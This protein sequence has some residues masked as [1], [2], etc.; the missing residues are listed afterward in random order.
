MC[1]RRRRE[2]R[3][4][5][6]GLAECRHGSRDITFGVR[7]RAPSKRDECRELCRLTPFHGD[8]LRRR[9]RHSQPLIKQERQRFLG[10][11]DLCKGRLRRH[12]VLDGS[13]DHI[14]ESRLESNR[15]AW[16]GGIVG[17][18]RSTDEAESVTVSSLVICGAKD[19]NNGVGRI[20][21]GNG[22]VG[23]PSSRA[24]RVAARNLR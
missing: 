13:T 20:V 2:R 15:A 21:L 17:A 1:A 11:E 9:E 10:V 16:T 12:L 7:L 19:A 6:C 18:A 23:N 24:E 3:V 8:A 22:A 4:E 14:E 5:S